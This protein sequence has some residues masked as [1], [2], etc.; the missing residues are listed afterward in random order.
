MLIA[1]DEVGTPQITQHLFVQD[2]TIRTTALAVL[3]PGRLGNQM[4]IEIHGIPDPKSLVDQLSPQT[5]PAAL[6]SFE[7][8]NVQLKPQ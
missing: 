5:S 8:A 7:R 2:L 1:Q 4:S 3:D 6:L